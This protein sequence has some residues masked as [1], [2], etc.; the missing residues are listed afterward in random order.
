MKKLIDTL[1]SMLLLI[2]VVI[3]AFDIRIETNYYDGFT[4]KHLIVSDQVMTSWFK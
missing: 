3:A 1:A 4:T 2:V